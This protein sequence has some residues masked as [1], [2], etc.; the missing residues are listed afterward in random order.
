MDSDPLTHRLTWTFQHS[1][2]T[3]SLQIIGQLRRKKPAKENE[4]EVWSTEWQE[5][6]EFCIGSRC[7]KRTT[8]QEE[9][10]GQAAFMLSDGIGFGSDS[11]SFLK[12][13]FPLFLALRSPTTQLLIRRVCFLKFYFQLSRNIWK[14]NLIRLFSFTEIF[15]FLGTPTVEAAGEMCYVWDLKHEFCNKTFTEKWM[16]AWASDDRWDFSIRVIKTSKMWF[17]R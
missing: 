1:L 17:E 11:V 4:E 3:F 14:T 12:S 6:E 16:N 10:F 2:Y 8:L 5:N 13:L 9:I 15:M 7:K